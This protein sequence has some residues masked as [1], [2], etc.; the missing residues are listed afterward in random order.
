MPS[1]SF[2]AAVSCLF[3]N[4]ILA[5]AGAAQGH[6]YTLYGSAPGESLGASLDGIGDVDRD[7]HADFIVGA[8][9]D[10]YSSSAAGTVRVYSGADGRVLFTFPGTAGQAL[11]YSVAGAGDV[12]NDGIPDVIVGAPDHAYVVVTPAPLRFHL[13][14]N[15]VPLTF[16]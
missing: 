10:P 11:G 1:P 16:E 15:P 12:D 6:L 5:A 4:C 8:P 3:A 7:G 9:D 2:C 14:S 13:S